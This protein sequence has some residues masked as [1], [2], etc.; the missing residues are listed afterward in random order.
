MLTEKSL[1]YSKFDVYSRFHQSAQLPKFKGSMLRGAM[2]HALKSTV[3]AVRVKVCDTCIL[4][5][6]C[7]YAKIFEV[8]PDLEKKTGQVNFPH[9]YVLESQDN[10]KIDFSPNQEFVFSIILFGEMI[11]YLPYF[12]YAFERMGEEGIGK[13]INGYRNSFDIQNICFENETIYGRQQKTL[14]GSTPSK[15]LSLENQN[16]DENSLRINVIFESPLR[17]KNQGKLVHDLEFVVFIR[18]ILRRIKTLWLRFAD[19]IPD[20]DEKGLLQIAETVEIAQARL[21]WEEQ[22]RYSNRQS[23]YLKLGGLKGSIEFSGN[24]TPFLPLLNIAQVVHI[25]KETSF[26]LGQLR[27][28]IIN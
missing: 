27:Y 20:F 15:S 17:V 6:N 5:R 7:L 24:L 9:P 25:G 21:Y 1:N 12:V 19:G 28:E 22:T 4:K 3:C 23:S 26:G 13:R 2:G 10:E 16:T 14:P 11:D 8:K 18:T